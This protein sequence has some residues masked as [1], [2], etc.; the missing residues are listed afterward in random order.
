MIRHDASDNST[1]RVTDSWA[2]PMPILDAVGVDVVGAAPS[3][4]LVTTFR[5]FQR[6]A[7]RSSSKSAS[8]LAAMILVLY[9]DRSTRQ[10]SALSFVTTMRESQSPISSSS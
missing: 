8:F 1:E 2:A 4:I 5:N 7:S 10:Q 3:T 6:S 9:Y